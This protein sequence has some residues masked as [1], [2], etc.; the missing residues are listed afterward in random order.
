[1]EES[2][3]NQTFYFFLAD[4][5]TPQKKSNVHMLILRNVLMDFHWHGIQL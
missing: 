4:L 3:Q 2:K 5:N 1:M